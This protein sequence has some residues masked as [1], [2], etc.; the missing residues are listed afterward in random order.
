MSEQMRI[1]SAG[2]AGM[3]V[4]LESVETTL[5]LLDRLLASEVDGVDEVVPG[6]RTVLVRFDPAV[7]D[8]AALIERL[9]QLDVSVRRERG[10]SMFDL[11]ASYVAEDLGEVA[12]LLGWSVAAL[13]QRH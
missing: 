11:P 13:V 3:L 2:S 7:I 10:R 5:A 9:G 12:E 6:A 4:E 1:L 8:R